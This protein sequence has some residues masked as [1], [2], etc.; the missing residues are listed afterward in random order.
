MIFNILRVD[1]RAKPTVLARPAVA[2]LA[3]AAVANIDIE[4][5]H[6]KIATFANFTLATF[7]W[8]QLIRESAIPTIYILN[9]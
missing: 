3:L 4:I 5:S 6:Y 8:N 1:E 2:A 7:L 9:I